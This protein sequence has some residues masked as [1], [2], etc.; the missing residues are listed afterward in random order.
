MEYVVNDV[1]LIGVRGTEFGRNNQI[2]P[3]V[4]GA[5]LHA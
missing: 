5:H 4:M 3:D 2:E 1:E